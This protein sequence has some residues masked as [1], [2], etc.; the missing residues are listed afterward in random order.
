M[1]SL[2]EAAMK[3]NL[4]TALELGAEGVILRCKRC[5]NLKVFSPAQSRARWP[6]TATFAE[7]AATARCRCGAKSCD[8]KPAW[9]LRSRGGSAPERYPPKDWGRF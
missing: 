3:R 2:G 5:I 8:A 6:A 1:G 7:I 9:K 4:E